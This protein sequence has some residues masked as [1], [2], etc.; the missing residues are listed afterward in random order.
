MRKILIVAA[1]L[2]LA[3]CMSGPATP[4]QMAQMQ[5][6]C[7]GYG[8]RQGTDA[9]ADC[10]ARMDQSRLATNQ[11][12]AQTIGDG[13]QRAGDSYTRAA[14]Q[15]IYTP[16]SVNCTSRNLGGGTVSTNCY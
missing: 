14:Q 6:T 15:P 1:L 11:M 12:R 13:F 5:A 9:F 8:Y 16:R 7:S 2:P 3:G 4:A 10:V